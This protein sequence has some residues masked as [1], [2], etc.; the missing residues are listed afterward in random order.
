MVSSW[1]LRTFVEIVAEGGPGRGALMSVGKWERAV[2]CERIKLGLG[3]FQEGKA[4]ERL[5]GM[6]VL[7]SRNHFSDYQGCFLLKT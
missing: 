5:F 2:I 6:R 7:V 3:W 1:G 4:I